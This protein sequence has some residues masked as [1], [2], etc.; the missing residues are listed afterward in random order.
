MTSMPIICSSKKLR[1]LFAI[2]I[3]ITIAL[4]VLSTFSSYADD[5]HLRITV[6]R[7]QIAPNSTLA[8]L[9]PSAWYIYL[10][11]TIDSDAPVRLQHEININDI[12][13]ALVFIN[14]P[15]GSVQAAMELGKIIRRN[16]FVTYVGRKQQNVN[17][18]AVYP[19]NVSGECYS[20]CVFAY[21][22]GNY[23]YIEPTSKIGVHRFHSASYK[24]A[25]EDNAQIVS[26][27]II[28]YLNEM[29]IDA[30]LFNLMSKA[31]KDELYILDNAE[32]NAIH[33]VN[34]GVL[35]AQWSINVSKGV[36]Y[37]KGEQET[38]YGIGKAMFAC[39]G[40]KSI[41]FAPFYYAG[42]RAQFIVDNGQHY[43]MRVGDSFIP[44]G[45]PN[46]P[47]QVNN[48]WIQAI[49]VLRPEHLNCLRS[50]SSVGLAIQSDNPG[51]FWGFNV[52]AKG[53]LQKINQFMDSCIGNQ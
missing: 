8:K 7:P 22:G 34:N 48:E 25:N 32:L 19:V 43:S 3:S 49:F 15:G 10:D 42:S 9:F 50:A 17:T 52:D 2:L 20:A 5:A 31:G 44:L 37:L 13:Y 30:S 29:G 40:N 35:P 38:V 47:I 11:G 6:I 28:S 41:L 26:A 4:I 45:K 27:A 53:S 24:Y 51:M 36:I 12:H 18:K 33:V 21:I 39:G 1:L 46:I 16:G 14:S 23:R